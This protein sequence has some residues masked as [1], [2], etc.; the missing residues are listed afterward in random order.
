MYLG[1]IFCVIGMEDWETRRKRLDAS[2][3][4]SGVVKKR[5]YN[6]YDDRLKLTYCIV[7]RQQ[8]SKIR[9]RNITGGGERG[10][11]MISRRDRILNEEFRREMQRGDYVSRR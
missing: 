5:K 6:I 9:Q 2:L 10:Y 8:A 3:E 1:V 7:Q 4:F 11:S